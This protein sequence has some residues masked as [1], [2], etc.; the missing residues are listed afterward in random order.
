MTGEGVLASPQGEPA[1][2]ID[3]TARGGEIEGTFTLTVFPA[4]GTEWLVEGSEYERI[5]PV[6]EMSPHITR[7][8]GYCTLN[9]AGETP[10]I[11]DLTKRQ[12]EDEPDSLSFASGAAA[13]PFLGM[14]VKLGCDCGPFGISFEGEFV[15]GGFEVEQDA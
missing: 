2:R 14:E 11:L 10:F 6:S 5:G 3:L 4:D 1:F 7:I 8:A 9:D 15:E 13:A 12:T